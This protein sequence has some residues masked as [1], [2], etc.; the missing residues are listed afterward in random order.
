MSTRKTPFARV[1]ARGLSRAPHEDLYH[2]ILTISWGQFLALCALAF[3]LANALFA[4]LY[5]LEPASILHAESFEDLF[6]FSV[7]TMATIG[8]GN[9]APATRYGH[10]LVTL[11]ALVGML[12][13]AL[14]TG[15]TFAKFSKPTARVLFSNKMVLG[16]RDGVPHLMLRMANLR[17]NQVVEATLRIVLLRTHVTREGDVLRV[18]LELSLVRSRTPVFVLSWLAM[19]RIDET[20]PLFG[21]GALAKLKAERAEM[22]VSL[23]GLDD[24]TGQT[25]H[26]RR[27][28]SLDDIAVGA[29]F[30]DILTT[31]D[32]GTRVI[33]YTKFHQVEAVTLENS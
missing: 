1:E 4:C 5:L 25:I 18:P 14:A 32:D 12:G 17:L 29:R 13:V 8:Y 9:M 10:V 30:V 24:T 15:L 22:F 31:R 21:E 11:E 3:L 6:F 33:E 19:H 16:P 2:W 7:Q 23:S 28:Y 27:S 20:S 26:A